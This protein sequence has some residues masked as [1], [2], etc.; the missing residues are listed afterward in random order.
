MSLL[1]KIEP[2][3]RQCRVGWGGVVKARSTRGRNSSGEIIA[4]GRMYDV[5][6][7]DGRCQTTDSLLLL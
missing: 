7:G 4:G 2:F 6:R 3:D 1:F 5:I